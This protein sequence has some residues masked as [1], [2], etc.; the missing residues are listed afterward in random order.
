MSGEKFVTLAA[1]GQV[2]GFLAGALP[3][4]DKTIQPEGK[5]GLEGR[6]ALAYRRGKAR[7]RDVK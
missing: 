3:G 1:A 6:K 2:T 4:K 7:A 5:S